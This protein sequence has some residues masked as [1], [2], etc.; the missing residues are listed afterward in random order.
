MAK[1]IEFPTPVCTYASQELTEEVNYLIYLCKLAD[2]LKK[3]HFVF[4]RKLRM[5]SLR[6]EMDIVKENIIVLCRA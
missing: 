2:N 3:K 4:F 6:K 5:K 1:I